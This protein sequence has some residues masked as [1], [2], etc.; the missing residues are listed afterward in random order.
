[1]EDDDQLSRL[2]QERAEKGMKEFC[3][4]KQLSATTATQLQELS[5]ALAAGFSQLAGSIKGKAQALREVR[6]SLGRD[7][8]ETL[9]IVAQELR[10]RPNEIEAFLEKFTLAEELAAKVAAL[11]RTSAETLNAEEEWRRL[12]P[13]APPFDHWRQ[14]QHEAA[15]GWFDYISEGFDLYYSRQL[16]ARLDQIVA[17]V[18]SLDLVKI[19]IANNSVKRL[20][21]EAH[22][23][24]LYGFDT[25]SIALCRSLIE[26]ALKDKFPGDNRTLA[27]L[28][29]R[30]RQEKLLEGRDLQSAR[31]V[32]TAGNLVMHN[33]ADPRK[34][35]E[36]TDCARIV[37][38]TRIVLNKLYGNAADGG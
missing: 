12:A 20:F 26:Q 15:E 25:A 23:A 34:T 2:R 19:E 6:R 14:S 24:F 11:S 32:A 4:D 37:N 29:E 8:L 5:T 38:C 33:A 16:V 22:E 31:D 18:S 17:R 30:A 10:D 35:R 7:R 28:I 13:D 3:T 1:M 9:E 36:I 27:P 21:Q